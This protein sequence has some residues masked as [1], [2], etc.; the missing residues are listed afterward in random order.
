MPFSHHLA[1]VPGFDREGVT[2]VAGRVPPAWSRPH[3]GRLPV[4]HHRKVH[5][6]DMS[7]GDMA[8]GI[9]DNE[10]RLSIYYMERIEPY[11]TLIRD[12]LDELNDAVENREGGVCATSVGCFLASPGA[13]V[14]SHFD[15]H[16]N[17]LLQLEG[18]KEITVADH[19]DPVEDQRV[20]EAARRWDHNNLAEL[21]TRTRTYAM[22]PGD[23]L[24]IPPHAF[25]W[26]HGGSDVSVALTYGFATPGSLRAPD[27]YWCN[28]NLRRL[29]LRPRPPRASERR[30]RAKAFAITRA[31]RVRDA[32]LSR[33]E[34]RGP[35]EP[36][37]AR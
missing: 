7:A 20:I 24:Y 15:L 32:V 3:S 21:P 22:G 23:G 31:A 25:H 17:F 1:G 12:T 33:R 35:A 14:P 18:T 9:A 8:R 29:G 26:V 37:S 28:A 34:R 2:A 16:H 27:V 5:L 13:V 10:S 30:D 36:A 4:L 11:R 6:A 19:D